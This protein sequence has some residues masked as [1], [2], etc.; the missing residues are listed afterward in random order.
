[1]KIARRNQGRLRIKA[2]TGAGAEDAA[3]GTEKRRGK[4]QSGKFQS[5]KVQI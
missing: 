5:G 2:F 3:R 4:F 1:M